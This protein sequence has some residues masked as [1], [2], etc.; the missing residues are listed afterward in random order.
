MS[1]H[2]S[3]PPSDPDRLVYAGLFALSQTT[4]F[5]LA[6]K[7]LTLPLAAAVGLFAVGIPLLGG[8]LLASIARSKHVSARPQS[9]F[10][11]L[12]GLFAVSMPVAGFGAFLLD[13]GW[14]FLA[15]YVLAIMVAGVGVRRM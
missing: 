3:R 4:V 11:S 13:F 12:F 14:P 7:H 2:E 1:S 10:S 9:Q 8:C 6:G 15:G 5:Q